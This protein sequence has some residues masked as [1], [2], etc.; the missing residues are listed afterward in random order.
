VAKQH[1]RPFSLLGHMHLNSVD[2]NGV[3]FDFRWHDM[4]P[5]AEFRSFYKT[6]A[7]R[8]GRAK[9]TTK[10]Q[11]SRAK[12]NPLTTVQPSRNQNL[13]ADKR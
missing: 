2:G 4:C 10:T 3:M 7:D 5:F 6:E 8:G 12:T 1:Q 13:N 11:R 9:P